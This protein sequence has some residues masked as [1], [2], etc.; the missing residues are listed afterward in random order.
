MDLQHMKS[1][2]FFT[3]W[4]EKKIECK[5]KERKS[6][7]ESTGEQRENRLKKRKEE[8]KGGVEKGTKAGG[9]TRQKW[10][11]IWK[12][13]MWLVENKESTVFTDRRN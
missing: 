8:R 4:K 9:E 10:R 7:T 6:G 1:A 13:E 11:E 3:C 12:K 5:W 2:V